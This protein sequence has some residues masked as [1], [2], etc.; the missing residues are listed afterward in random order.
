MSTYGLLAVC[1]ELIHTTLFH[2]F[3]NRGLIPA[4]HKTEGRGGVDRGVVVTVVVL[5]KNNLEVELLRSTEVK[6]TCIYL[7]VGFRYQ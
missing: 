2:T 7:A 4:N 1:S 6:G 5:A 3:S